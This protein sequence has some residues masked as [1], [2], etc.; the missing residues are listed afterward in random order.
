MLS[1]TL[2]LLRGF[3]MLR[4]SAYLQQR[5]VRIVPHMIDTV[6]L[7]SA[8]GL[9]YILA[10]YPF[11]HSWLTAKVIALVAYIVFGSLA[12]KRGRSKPIKV[13]ALLVAI[14]VFA[15]IVMVAFQHNPWPFAAI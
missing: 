5:W 15:Y 4:D 12:L 11:V 3:W 6:L 2:F 9:V 13:T 1:G 10:Q 7:L 14:S 8:I